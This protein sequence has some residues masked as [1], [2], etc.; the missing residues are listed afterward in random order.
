MVVALAV[1]TGEDPTIPPVRQGA[2]DIRAAPAIR[3]VLQA[4]P[5]A[6]AVLIPLAA[7]RRTQAEDR[8]PMQDL[9]PLVVRATPEV[10]IPAMETI[11]RDRT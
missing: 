1:V 8:I 6:V 7:V 3:R 9:V 4:D 5:R 2:V 11:Q 10:I